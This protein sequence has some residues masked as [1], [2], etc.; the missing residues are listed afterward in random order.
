M[1]KMDGLEATRII[2]GMQE[3]GLIKE[4]II[5][6][7]LSA[8]GGWTDKNDAFIAGGNAF[9]NKPLMLKDLIDVFDTFFSE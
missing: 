3:E 7:F 9:L 6:V 1:P 2:R 5:I 8:Y 4:Q